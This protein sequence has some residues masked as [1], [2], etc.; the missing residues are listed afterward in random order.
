M[1]GVFPDYPASVIRHNYTGT[2]MTL[3]RWGMPAPTHRWAAGYQYPQHVITAL[4]AG[5]SLSAGAWSRPIASRSTRPR[6]TRDQEVVKFALNEDRPLFAFAGNWT[7]F[8][9]DRGTVN[10]R[11]GPRPIGAGVTLPALAKSRC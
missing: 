7:T 11:G 8:N 3:M 6:R 5:S 9:G 1:P 10:R 4:A 2:E